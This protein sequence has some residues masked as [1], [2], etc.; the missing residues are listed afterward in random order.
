[1]AV[2]AAGPLLLTAI[3]LS[4]PLLGTVADCSRPA[5]H[6]TRA[7]ATQLPGGILRS[8]NTVYLTVRSPR[9]AA[10]EHPATGGA[11][12]ARRLM[13]SVAKTV[14]AEDLRM[15]D[16]VSVTVISTDDTSNGD[17][18]AIYRSYFH[19]SYPAPG[20]VRAGTLSGGAHFELVAVA[21]RPRWLQL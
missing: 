15:D 21:V 2:H 10:G 17:F 6:L 7:A 8:G 3:A 16:L 13:D 9:A 5:P 14:A 20:Y 11:A 19:A 1:M 12:E 4:L 18:D